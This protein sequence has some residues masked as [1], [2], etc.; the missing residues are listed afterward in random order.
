M[1]N[2]QQ[3]AVMT[4]EELDARKKEMLK[5]Y[6]ESMPYLKAQFEYEEMLFKIDEA[7]FKRSSLQIQ[8]AMMMQGANSEGEDPEGSDFDTDPQP[9]ERKLKKQ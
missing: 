5:F 1:E 8:F 6:K 3:E 7:R 4:A 2:Q 9:K